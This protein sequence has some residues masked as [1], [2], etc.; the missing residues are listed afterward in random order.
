MPTTDTKIKSPIV[1]VLTKA[2]YNSISSPSSE[3][4]YLIT[5]DTN[6]VAGNGIEATTSSNGETLVSLSD[7]ARVRN[8]TYADRT[9]EEQTES[10]KKYYVPFMN[11]YV[12]NTNNNALLANDGLGYYSRQGTDSTNGYA[13]LDLGNNIPR[14]T[15]GNKWGQINFWYNGY[16]TQMVSAC[17]A[18]NTVIL[19]A[20]NPGG[21]I[22]LEGRYNLWSG[23]LTGGNS[24][25]IDMSGCTRIRVYAQT[26]GVQHIF[27]I[28]LRDE[29]K[30]TSGLIDASYPYQGG[31]VVGCYSV[32]DS[33]GTFYHYAVSCKVNANKN[34]LKVFAMGYSGTNGAFQL[35]NGSTQY[36]VY[37]VDG[38]IY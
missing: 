13:R 33:T 29:G 22:Y 2:Q 18:T 11:G 19:P 30:A 15:A 26:W 8:A 4:F 21:N 16:Y 38:I 7:T 5:D 23:T 24:V 35:Q 14:G 36:Y 31:S 34:M 17:Q 9:N 3:E 37:R 28:N 12:T 10:I 6:I 1:N 20:T 32:A 27:E 25:T